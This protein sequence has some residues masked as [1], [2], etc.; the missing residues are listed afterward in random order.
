MLF[1]SK[2]QTPR[3]IEFSPR[4]FDGNISECDNPEQM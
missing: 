1:E 2:K 3:E 4:Q